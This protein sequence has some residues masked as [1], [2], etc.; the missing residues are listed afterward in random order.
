MEVR[1]IMA[2]EVKTCG[3]ETTLA[4]VAHL[5][6]LQNIGSVPVVNLEGRPMGIVTDRD[7]AMSSFLNHRSLWELR[8][9][10]VTREQKIRTCHV[11][12]PVDKAIGMMKDYEIRR[13]PVIDGNGKLVGMLSFGD[14]VSVA[15]VGSPRKKSALS[16]NALAPAF[17]TC[18]AHHTLV[19]A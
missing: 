1:E 2:D 18:F 3:P 15:E 12:D 13:L 6:W 8:A 11:D 19:S 17:K 16:I 14:M 7:I 5:M 4:S 9:C 10:D